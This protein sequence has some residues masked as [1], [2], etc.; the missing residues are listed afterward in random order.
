MRTWSRVFNFKLHTSTNIVVKVLTTIIEEI[1][2]WNDL[3]SFFIGMLCFLT[4]DRLSGPRQNGLMEEINHEAV[5]IKSLSRAKSLLIEHSF[6]YYYIG[7]ELITKAQD[8]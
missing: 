4:L 8:K 7:N 5:T 3:V 2:K 1:L 6:Y